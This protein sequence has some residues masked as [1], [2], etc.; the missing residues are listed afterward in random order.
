MFDERLDTAKRDCQRKQPDIVHHGLPPC[1]CIL[2]TERYHCTVT[3]HLALRDLV[4]WVIGKAGVVDPG[5]LRV[6]FQK[7]RKLGGVL[8]TL[9]HPQ[10]QRLHTTKHKPRL[11]GVHRSTEVVQDALDFAVQ[12]FVFRY[13]HPPNDVAVTVDVLCEAVDDDVRTVLEGALEVGT[14]ATP[15]SPV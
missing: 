1:E 8:L 10:R 3:V 12:Y 14:S 7:L 4:L 6:I 9:L 13:N 11:V 2:H 15:T 5:D